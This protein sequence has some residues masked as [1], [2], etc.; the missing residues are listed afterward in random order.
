MSIGQPGIFLISFLFGVES[1]KHTEG[2]EPLHDPQAGSG[3]LAV[4]VRD[5]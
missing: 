4:S 5:P 3:R 1:F 2:T